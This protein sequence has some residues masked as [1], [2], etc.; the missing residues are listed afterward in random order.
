MIL[1]SIGMGLLL[2]GV[3]VGWMLNE[4]KHSKI[5][6]ILRTGLRNADNYKPGGRD[7]VVL[8]YNQIAEAMGW[9]SELCYPQRDDKYTGKPEARYYPFRNQ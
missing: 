9:E 3:V 8:L 5:K 7:K 4:A 1:T 2:L 6:A